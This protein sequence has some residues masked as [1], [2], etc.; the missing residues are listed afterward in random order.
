MR[1]VWKGIIAAVILCMVFTA[2]NVVYATENKRAEKRVVFD[3]AEL[4][5]D[6][7]IDAL[8]KQ[9]TNLKEKTGWEIFAVTTANANGK[10]AMAYADDFY[11][12]RTAESAD[13]F[14]V[15][16]DM[17]NREIY[18][19]T[20]GKAIRYLTDVRIERVLD[21]GYSYISNG[22]YASG[23]SSM[24]GKAEQYY[25]DG[26]SKNQYNYDV[27]TG[28]VS[29]YHALTWTEILPIFLLSAG[30]GLAIYIG[31]KK[32]YR[33][34]GG[35]YEYPYMKYGEMKL[36]EKEDRFIRAHTMHQRIQTD[37]GRSG[38]SHSGGSGQS[39]THHSSGGRSHG[40]GGRK[41]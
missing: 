13:G 19:S 7:E 40:G 16:I 36:I 9:I 2:S 1:K 18:I 17:D 8:A 5:Q 3:D 6:E 34:K 4:M 31:V 32:S 25:E 21:A 24:I 30:V 37:S 38:G 28:A 10:T 29:K 15:L 39:S 27:E 26:I 33:L 23:L 12:E 22:E 20:Q 11:D 41:F 35:R 14:L